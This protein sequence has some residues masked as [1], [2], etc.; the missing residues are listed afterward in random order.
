MEWTTP[1]IKHEIPERQG[2][3]WLLRVR[4]YL[5]L[6]AAAGGGRAPV[7]RRNA[8]IHVRSERHSAG[9]ERCAKSVAVS[10]IRLQTCAIRRDQSDTVRCAAELGEVGCA[11]Q[12]QASFCL[13]RPPPS[14]PS[15]LPPS[16]IHPDSGLT[17][18]DSQVKKFVLI[19][20]IVLDFFT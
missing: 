3:F 20:G 4:S 16:P 9:K 17:H 7:S 1:H 19:K 8:S 11:L 10:G 15:P 18:S 6:R 14:P 2:F 5:A 13:V 12:T